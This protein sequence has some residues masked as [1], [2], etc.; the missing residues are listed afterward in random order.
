[1]KPETPLRVIAVSVL[2]FLAIICLYYAC[3]FSMGAASILSARIDRRL[4]RIPFDEDLWKAEAEIPKHE[5]TPT[6]EY[7]ID[8]L[9]G[10]YDFTEWHR[11]EVVELLGEP[12]RVHR[13]RHMVYYMLGRYSNYFCLKFD[14]NDLVT[15]YAVVQD[16]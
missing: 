16:D 5:R 3:G 2:I 1:M 13:N 11:N 14:A 12:D 10:Q 8:D 9:L 4:N 15:E 7:M 6:R